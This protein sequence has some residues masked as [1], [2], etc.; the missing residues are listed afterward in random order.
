M[1]DYLCDCY[2]NLMSK[3]HEP[4]SSTTLYIIHSRRYEKPYSTYVRAQLDNMKR[5]ILTCVDDNKLNTSNVLDKEAVSRL[6]VSELDEHDYI[7][8]FKELIHE[9]ELIRNMLVEAIET[10]DISDI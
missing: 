3:G 1:N 9:N 2:S 6:L 5:F 8:A 10:E 7:V 4:L